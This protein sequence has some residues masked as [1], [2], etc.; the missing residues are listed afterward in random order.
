M[1][2]IVDNNDEIF[3]NLPFNLFNIFHGR[4]CRSKIMLGIGEGSTVAFVAS[5]SAPTPGAIAKAKSLLTE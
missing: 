4:S 5:S 2:F 1:I 3:Q